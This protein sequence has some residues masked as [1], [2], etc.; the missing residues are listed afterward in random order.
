MNRGDCD[1]TRLAQRDQSLGNHLCGRM[2][3][4]LVGG[5]F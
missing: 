5:F 3:F 1:E 2:R 4:R